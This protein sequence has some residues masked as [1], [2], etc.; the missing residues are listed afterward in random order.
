MNLSPPTVR[1]ARALA[2]SAVAAVLSL[3]ALLPGLA[4]AQVA[5][6]PSVPAA[7]QVP[8]GNVLFL[9]GHATGTQNYA[10]QPSSSAPAGYEWTLVAPAATLVDDEGTPI[11]AH[12]AGPSWQAGDGSTVVGARVDGETVSP[13]AIPWLLLRATSTSPGPDGGDGLTA[14]TYVQRVNTTGGLAPAVGCDATTAGAAAEVPYTSDYYFF[15]AAD[16]D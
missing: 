9:L 6:P 12:F 5:S 2:G 14:A 13:S 1:P 11:I 15:K 8:P 7:I 4:H 16:A 10:C 3:S